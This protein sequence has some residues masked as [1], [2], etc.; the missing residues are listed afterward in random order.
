MMG[1]FRRIRRYLAEPAFALA[2]WVG[3]APATAQVNVEGAGSTF[4]APIIDKWAA[5]YGR[6]TGVTITYQSVGSGA[7][8]EKIKAGE[9]DFGASDKPLDPSELARLGLCQFPV[10]IGG[11]VPVVNLPGV[12]PGKIKFSGTLLAEIFMGKVKRWDDPAIHAINADLNLP[13][14]PITVVHRSDGSGTTYN[15]VDYLAKTN[16]DWRKTVG[17]G[18]TVNWPTGIAGNG[19]AGVA[20]A[21][22][23]TRGALG[24]VEYAYALQNRLAYGQIANAHELFVSP[25]ADSFQAAAETVDWRRLI[26]SQLPPLYSCTRSREIGRAAPPL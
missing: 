13:A 24:Y 17:V 16:A 14:L 23:Q 3:I 11:V 21:V 22:Q 20:S 26:Q 2:L 10:V 4:V 12:A 25:N 5:D 15:W 8:I 9:V 18:L 7:G 1:P 19:N 6:Q